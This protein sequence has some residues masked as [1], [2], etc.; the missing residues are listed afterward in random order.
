MPATGLTTTFFRDI[1]QR[2]MSEFDVKIN[3]SIIDFPDSSGH[4]KHICKVSVDTQGK[5]LWQFETS[6]HRSLLLE[7]IF[8][9]YLQPNSSSW[10]LTAILVEVN[11]VFS[12]EIKSDRIYDALMTRKTIIESPL[13]KHRAP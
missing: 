6:G 1:E 9:N 5:P 12:D 10:P 11:G 4:V 2:I 8:V 13:Y 3:S 7:S